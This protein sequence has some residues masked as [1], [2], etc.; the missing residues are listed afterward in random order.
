MTKK[1]SYKDAGVDIAAGEEAVDR[2]KKMV[3]STFSPHVLSDLGKFGGFFAPDLYGYKKPVFVSSIDGVGTKLKVAFLMGKHD[4]VGEDLV[5]H[6]INDILAGGARPLFFLD[7]I[8]TGKLSPAVMEEIVTGMVRGCKQAGCALIGGEMAEMP[9]FYQA[10]EYDVAGCI[11]G[12]VDENR[13]IDG[14]DIHKGDLLIGL[15]SNGLHTNGYS[16]AR[17]IL[18]EDAGYQ[19]ETYIDELGMTIGEALLQVHTCY[20]PVISPLLE[21]HGIRGLSHV[22]GGGIIGNTQRILPE[23]RMLSIDWNSWEILPIFRLIQKSGMVSDEEMHRAFNLGIGFICIVDAGK[24]DSV[25]QALR[26]S[27]AKPV[28]IGQVG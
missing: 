3:R 6:C 20:L 19:V 27:G 21:T 15:P 28:I 9:G 4:T 25:L 2:I 26:D 17:K 23:G 1:T 8:G 24:S 10:G 12:L 7:Y 14:S 16:L 22:T 11:V 5:N 13:I 18:F